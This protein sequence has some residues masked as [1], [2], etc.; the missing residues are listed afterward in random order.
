MNKIPIVIKE[1]VRA[2]LNDRLGVVALESTLISHGLPY[3]E[4]IEIA[5]KMENNVREEG[6]I[7]ATIAI[8]NGAF[9]IGLDKKSIEYLADPKSTVHKVSR[10]DIAYTLYSKAT[11]ATTVSGTMIGAHLSGIKIFATGGLGG[12][13]RGVEETLDISTDLTELSR[14]P[15]AVVCSGVKSIL[16]ISKT[17][18]MLETLGVPIFGYK[19]RYFPE[20]YCQGNH[21]PLDMHFDNE[22]NIAEALKIHWSLNL[23]SGVIIA[24][25]VPQKYALANT[26]VER[27]IEE[28]IAHAHQKNIQGK[29]LTPFLLKDLGTRSNKTST[30]TNCAL[31]LENAR[32]AARIAAIRCE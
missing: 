4:N 17:L 14:T 9:H 30:Q 12:V 3:P 5:Q 25:N 15:V 32:T 23:N 7:P 20:F 28:A 18:E 31:L 8:L 1:E 13:H 26:L 6:A 19:T 21:Y 24:Q 11:G 2:A 29:G 10:R 27:W 16:D 22:E